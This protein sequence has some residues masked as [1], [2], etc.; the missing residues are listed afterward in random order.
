MW[1]NVCMGGRPMRSLLFLT[2]GVGLAL[3]A[4][5][6]PGGSDDEPATSDSD[7]VGGKRDLRWA[8]GGYLMRDGQS[9]VGCGATLI[10]K[11]V[12]VTAAHCMTADPKATWSF[13]TGDPGGTRTKVVETHIH[14]DFHAEADGMIDLTNALRLYDVAWLVLEHPV[15]GVE[16]AVLPDALPSVGCNLQAVGYHGDKQTRV[17]APACTVLRVEL[18][19]DPIFEVHP[20]SGSALCMA[21]GDEGSAVFARDGARSV[22]VGLFAGSVTQGLTDCVRGTQFLDGYESAYGYRAFLADALKR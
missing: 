15:D 18:G 10:T 21:D 9:K 1:S 19:H 16:P 12:V 4:C 2:V 3:A 6:A 7:L 13:G 22:F 14:P 5:A 17:S 11:D 8:A 20:A